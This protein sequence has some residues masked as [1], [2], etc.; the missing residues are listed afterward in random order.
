MS[1]RGTTMEGRGSNTW[2]ATTRLSSFN[3][4]LHEHCT[5]IRSDFGISVEIKDR[6]L[7]AA[8]FAW[9][10][11]VEHHAA[12]PRRNTPDYFQF[13]IGALLAQLL[14]SHAI[15]TVPRVDED[16]ARGGASAIAQ[17]W[18]VGFAL[19]TFCVELVRKVI[20]QECGEIV[21]AS[22]KF[23][24]IKL[25]QSFRENL[26]EE[27]SIAIAYFDAFMGL[28]PNWRNPSFFRERAA[29]HR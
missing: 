21:A 4:L 12:D 2:R 17:W 6:A 23:G 26:S 18:P 15:D 16:R 7:T 11:I 10:Q 20:A 27:P 19:T 5:A 3:E 24:D 22:E 8:F 1:E 14:A 25:W 29:A 28:A 9:A 13:L